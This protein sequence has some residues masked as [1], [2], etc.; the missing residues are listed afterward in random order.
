MMESLCRGF[1]PEL[2]AGCL[3]FATPERRASSFV[4]GSFRE[5]H[6]DLVWRLDR[7]AESRSLYLLLEFQS[8]P[9]PLM[10]LRLL[11]YV[12]LLLEDLIRQ[13]RYKPGDELPVVFVVVLYTGTAPWRAPLDVADLFGA[14]PPGLRCH[15]PSLRY[16]LLDAKRLDLDRAGLTENLAAAVLRIDT[17]D[18]PDDFPWLLY[19]VLKLATRQSD[20][21]LRSSIT[22]WLRRK[23]RKVP[24]RGIMLPEPEETTMLEETAARWAKGL[25]IKGMRRVLLSQLRQ[26]FGRVPAGMRRAV[27]AIQSERELQRLAG[28]VL[29]VKSLADLSLR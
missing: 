14:P 29:E 5:R 12:S 6:S 7:S 16:V 24:F 11:T 15:I 22:A 4:S 2:G 21:G 9:D 20:T 3:D 28:R 18:S 1:L 23:L 10:P 17:C 26:R 19:Q 27:E 8:T 25:M 13:G